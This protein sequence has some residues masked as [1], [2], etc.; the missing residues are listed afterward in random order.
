MEQSHHIC[1]EATQRMTDALPQRIINASVSGEN[2]SGF[3]L[4]H[5]SGNIGNLIIWQGSLSSHIH[6]GMSFQGKEM[7]SAYL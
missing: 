6:T 2:N 5:N 7:H 3:M 4:A 1:T